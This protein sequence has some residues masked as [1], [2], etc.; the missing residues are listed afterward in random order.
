[1]KD[2]CLLFREQCRQRGRLVCAPVG[3]IV[4]SGG[5]GTN[6]FQAQGSDPFSLTIASKIRQVGRRSSRGVLSCSEVGSRS[7]WCHPGPRT[8]TSTSRRH[9]RTSRLTENIG[10]L[11]AGGQGIVGLGDMPWQARRTKPVRIKGGE[12]GDRSG[13][14]RMQDTKKAG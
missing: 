4:W 13:K 10:P 5:N 6:L 7:A 3:W 14:S 1:M 9:H 8:C 12:H 11:V 2:G